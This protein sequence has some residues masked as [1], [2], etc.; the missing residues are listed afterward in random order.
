MRCG[1]ALAVVFFTAAM[2]AAYAACPDFLPHASYGTGLNSH[3][4]KIVKA[5][6]N[7]DGRVDVAVANPEIH[8]IGILLANGPGTFGTV[9]LHDVGAGLYTYALAT[10][11]FNRDGRADLVVTDLNSDTLRIRLGNGTGGFTTGDTYLTRPSP[12][13]ITTADVNRDGKLDILTANANGQDV[14]VFLGDGSGGFATPNHYPV[15]ISPQSIAVDDFDGDGDLDVAAAAGNV[16]KTLSGDGT[17]AFG[18]P[19]TI[20]LPTDPFVVVNGMV[21]GDFNRDGRRDIAALNYGGTVVLLMRNATGFDAPVQHAAGAELSAVTAGD[22]NGDGVTDL[23]ASSHSYAAVWVVI[24]NTAGGF[25]SP[26]NYPV[27]G[28]G[29]DLLSADFNADGRHDL[30]SVNQASPGRVSILLN[31]GA[32]RANCG[33]FGTPSPLFGSYGGLAVATGDVNGD[34]RLDLAV[35]TNTIGVSV[36]L[37]SGAAGNFSLGSN[38]AAGTTP[39][40]VTFADVNLDGRLDLAVANR[41]SDDMSVLLGDGSGGFAAASSHPVCA[42]SGQPRSIAGGDFNRDGREDF[43][44]VCG[45]SRQLGILLNTTAP[46]SSTAS[47][48]ASAVGSVG[49]SL[50]PRGLAAG[51]FNKDGKLDVAVANY[52]DGFNPGSVV[53]LMGDGAGAFTAGTTP[54]AGTGP[55][56]VGAGDFNGDGILDLAVVN[57]VSG[58]VSILL[59]NGS[60]G[61][62]SNGTVLVETDAVAI[63]VGDLDKDFDLDLAVANRAGDNVAIL[64]GN[65]NGSFAA[66]SP[67]IHSV[68][69]PEGVAAGD[70]DRDG[71]LDLAIAT[72]GGAGVSDVTVLLNSCPAADLELTAQGLFGLQQGATASMTISVRNAAQNATSGKVTVV[73]TL[74]VSLPAN[75]I[76]GTGWTCVLGTLTCTRSD[77]LAFNMSYEDITVDVLVAPNAPASVT[78]SAALS[79]G[80]QANAAN[81]TDSLVRDVSQSPDM[82]L[83]K[84]HPNYFQ[85]GDIGMTYI[86]TVTN[87]GGA[88]WFGGLISVTDTLP[89]GL[90]ATA[91]SGTGWFCS[92]GT[93][94]CSRGDSL[95]AGLSYPAITLTVNVASNAAEWVTNTAVVNG[96]SPIYTG[97]DTATDLTYIYQY[98][99][100]IIAKT[101]AG[102]FQQ[103]QTGKTYSIVVGN[104][105][106]V[107]TGGTV[108]VVDTLPAGLT[109]TAIAGTGW[110]C[111]LGTLTCTRSDALAPAASYAPIVLTVSVASNAPASVTNTATVSGGGEINTTNDVANDVTTVIQFTPHCGRFSA[112]DTYDPGVDSLSSIAVGDFNGDGNRDLV[113]AGYNGHRIHIMAGSGNGSLSLT[114]TYT[115]GTYPVS[116]VTGDFNADGKLDL[117]TANS[118][119]SNASVLIG[120]GNGT[121]IAA[122]PYATGSNPQSVAVGDFNGDGKSDLVAANG[123]GGVSLLVGNGDGTFIGATSHAFGANPKAV[124]AG[125]FNADGKLDLAVAHVA[126]SLVA[127]RLG[128]GDGTFAPKVDYF[129]GSV[130]DAVAAGDLNNDGRAD[131]AVS[132]EVSNDVSVMIANANGTFGATVNYAAGATPRHVAMVDVNGDGWMDL[133]VAS[134]G[135]NA[136][137]ILRNNGNGTFAAATSNAVGSEPFSV[138][139]GDFTGDGRPELVTANWVGTNVSMLRSGCPDLYVMKSHSGNLTQGQTGATYSLFVGNAGTAATAGTVTVTDNLPAELVATEISGTGWNCTL[140]TLTCTRSDAL[141]VSGNYPAITLTV[142]VNSNAP[143]SITNSASVSGGSDESPGNNSATDPTTIEVSGLIAPTRFLATAASASQINLTWDAVTTAVSYQVYRSDHN[144]AFTLITTVPGTTY[145]NTGLAANTT[146][147]YR[148]QAVNGASAVSGPSNR[149]LA[150]TIVFLDDSVIAGTTI[151]KAVHQTEL[152]TAVNAVRAAAGLGNATFTNAIGAG[153]LIRAADM[154]EL[155]SALDAARG[156]IGVPPLAYTDPSLAGV[157]VKA[158]HLQEIRAGTK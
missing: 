150:T 71:T 54:A 141:G 36:R 34:G 109:A 91:M 100:L 95:D 13:A 98:P 157:P 7:G 35:T 21:T 122:V 88:P 40:G 72:S 25:A 123:G 73:V 76:G 74:P 93:L 77:S 151:I 148:V 110:S 22:F 61:F 80:S 96:G 94:T 9:T 18:S 64:L 106:G 92:L 38:P 66:A 78:A 65:G 63:A 8:S 75:A 49:T 89:A 135:A 83:T 5:D 50:G 30:A 86:L 41:F 112:A 114:N 87:V 126:G 48:T 26:T 1:T 37:A 6:F 119:S 45:A 105:G 107:A 51:D 47:F 12:G 68:T 67:S 101:H 103:H 53:L 121:F 139:A 42:A 4:R 44:V 118:G 46:G 144:G 90:T 108:T 23:A 81:D 129:A 16:I 58:N 133:V 137:S 111:T 132:N 117:A 59:G 136:V 31:D 52:G 15:G 143:S 82:A 43:A 116:V 3:P 84:S 146:Y 134:S 104:Q 17:G 10:G 131:L 152:R 138:A 97:N 24:G 29:G 145:P 130:P 28:S 60:G 140:A 149:D 127:V 39:A 147:V 99:D 33:T 153:G 125:D 124:A 158:V 113:V 154:S 2:P 62:T 155:R 79:G 69:S 27:A 128:N 70:F 32:C 85:Q 156:M 102:N 120:N 11:D 57:S 115:T 142:S 55:E 19:T 14:S 20:T 56:A